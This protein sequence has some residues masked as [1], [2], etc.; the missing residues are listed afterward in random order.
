MNEQTQRD[1]EI[2]EELFTAELRAG[3]SPLQAYRDLNVN[4][5]PLDGGKLTAD[6][7]IDLERRIVALE[8]HLGLA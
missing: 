5:Y 6:A 8:A 7:L 1:A 4:G 2:I 3:G